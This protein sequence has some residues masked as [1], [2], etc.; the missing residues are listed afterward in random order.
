MNLQQLVN[1]LQDI[2]TTW[3]IKVVGVLVA[4]IVGWIVAN[5]LSGRLRKTLEARNFDLTLT[6]FFANLVR[7][8][9]LAG[10]ALGCLGVFGIETTSFAGLIAAAGLAIGLAFQGTLSNFA[11]GVMLLIF[12]PFKV[13]DF[14]KVAG[15][16]GTVEEVELFTCEFKSLDNRRLIVPNSA[17]FG[18]TINNVTHYPI[19]R[20]DVNVGCAY[21]AD[22][23]AC[24]AVFEKVVAQVQGGLSEPA[25]QVFLAGLGASS[26]DW[27]LRIWCNTGDYWDVFQ[28]T[29]RD[30]KKALED[31]DIGIPFPQMD[32]H[33]DQASREA[34][35][36]R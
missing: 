15:I 30:A 1:Q 22:I 17:I 33:L 21:D 26:V 10:V 31:A 23:D 27:Q 25:P 6:R 13:G 14:V 28:A 20:V 5:R 8:A 19:R 29:I 34:L 9:I 32:V 16:E 2:A 3:G 24:R 18:A 7:Y 4:A 36:K 35:A 11:A 12:R